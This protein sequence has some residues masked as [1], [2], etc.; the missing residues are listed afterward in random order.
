MSDNELALTSLI[1]SWS[2]MRAMTSGSRM[3]I[4]NCPVGNL[5]SNGIVVR[6]I[7]SVQGMIRTIRRN[8][9][10]NLAVDRTTRKILV[11]EVR[12]RTRW[13]DRAPRAWHLLRESCG[14]GREHEMSSWEIE[15]GR[16]PKDGWKTSQERSD[17]DGSGVHTKK[18]WK[19]KNMS[20]KRVYIS[21]ENLEEFGFTARCPGCMSLFRGIARQAH[22]ESCRRRI[23][24]ELQGTAKAHASTRRM[25]QHQTESLRREQNGR[26]QT[27]KKND[28][29]VNME[30]RQ[31]GWNKMHQF[32][33]QVA[34]ATWYRRRVQTAAAQ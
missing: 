22:T 18:S 14:I 15:T 28:N 32:R 5:K 21:R 9:A 24:E 26:E 25:K 6:A 31:L 3:I 16:W 19:Q 33:I 11:D 30:N 23:E 1:A 20:Q 13:E 10:F 7:Q 17:S 4:E 34:V 2:T 27:R 8:D 12:G 29:S